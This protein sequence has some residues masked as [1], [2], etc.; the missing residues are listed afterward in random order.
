LPALPR[1]DEPV[2]LYPLLGVVI[3]LD[4]SKNLDAPIRLS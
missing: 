4:V 2:L 3:L 1:A